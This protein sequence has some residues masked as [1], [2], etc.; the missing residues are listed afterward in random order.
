MIGWLIQLSLLRVEVALDQCLRVFPRTL[1]SASTVIDEGAAA[2]FLNG[3]QALSY[4][5]ALQVLESAQLGL[6]LL[7]LFGLARP[8]QVIIATINI[9]KGYQRMQPKEQQDEQETDKGDR[10][11]RLRDT[12]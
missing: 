9:D 8:E 3:L 5:L 11:G 12:R 10:Q 1:R 4:L 2:H 7:P 6:F